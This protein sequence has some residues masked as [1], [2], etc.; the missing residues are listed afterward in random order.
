MTIFIKAAKLFDGTGAAPVD[1]PVVAVTG[2]V[3]SAIYSAADAPSPAA[4]DEVVE[5]A[6]GTILPGLIDTHVHL[7]LPG[8][9]KTLE[10]AMVVGPEVMIGTSMGN[11]A[12]ALGAG[13]TT[14]RDLGAFGTTS[15]AAKKALAL[16]HAKGA[17]VVACGRPLTITGGH[18]RYMGG[19]TDGE[20]DLRK[21]VRELIREG[22]DFI[23]VMGSGGGTLGSASWRPSYSASEM[24]AIVDEA[25]RNERMVTVHCLCAASID[26]AIEAGVDQ[27]E[28][29]AF[30]TDSKGNQNYDPAA[31]DRLAA[32]GIPVTSTLAVN[33][34]LLNMVRQ[35]VNPTPE[36]QA[37]RDRWERST[38][39]NM[40]H[41]EKMRAA[42]VTYVAG[43]DA[44]WRYTPTDS[45]VVEL[46]MMNRAGMTTAE[47]LFAGTGGAADAIHMTERAGRVLVGRPA[48]LIVTN[49]D[50]FADLDAL[51]DLA[52]VMQDG[53][54]HQVTPREEFAPASQICPV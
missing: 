35:I 52:L 45:M 17:K 49:G 12:R 46:E 28:H 51:R 44:G 53:R 26:I 11:A 50:P 4:G 47:A 40:L 22:A 3:I 37:F 10:E 6:G 33:G 39:T 31:A 21:R 38:A 8:D 9:G 42:G 7:N 13:I 25:H 23:K 41:F 36:Q 16:G 30:I 43:T 48:D 32:S 5:F 24:A 54:R 18:C 15:F 27:L 34:T 14:L 2:G 19:E 29:G 20:V 1:A